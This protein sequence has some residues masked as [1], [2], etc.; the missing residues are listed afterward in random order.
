MTRG[1][2]G[3]YVYFTDP[4]TARFVRDR[5]ASE[6]SGELLA[7]VAEPPSAYGSSPP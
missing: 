4:S 2:K 1:L 5:I 7:E 3:C 6:R